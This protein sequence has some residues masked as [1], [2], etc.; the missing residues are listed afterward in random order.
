MVINDAKV[1]EMGFFFGNRVA[2]IAGNKQDAK[3]LVLTTGQTGTRAG[4]S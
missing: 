4:N 1:A 3:I 2:E